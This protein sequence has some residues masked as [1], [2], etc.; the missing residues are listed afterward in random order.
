MTAFDTDVLTEILMGNPAFVQRA[1]A[2]PRTQQA[3]P[4]VVVEEIL[5]GRLEAIRRAESG[6]SAISIERSYELF[7]QTFS[8]FQDLPI[9][10]YT[11]EAESL[12]R[13]WRKDRIR[14]STH[15]LRI[16]A[17]AVAHSCTLVSRNRRDF[18][19]VPGLEVEY[20]G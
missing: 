17:I 7:S 5:R 4:V 13:Q 10:S 1:R 15:D 12:Y 19:Q 11:S 6:K 18:D 14:I 20:W 16:A 3:V 8:D 2:I 9:L